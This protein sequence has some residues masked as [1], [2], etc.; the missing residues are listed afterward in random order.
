MENSEDDE[1]IE[2][3]STH[4]SHKVRQKNIEDLLHHANTLRNI[5]QV[6]YMIVN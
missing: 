3:L 4:P 5:C 6:K 1:K 2:W